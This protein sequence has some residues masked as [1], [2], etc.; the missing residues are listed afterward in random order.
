MGRKVDEAGGVGKREEG[1]L[2]HGGRESEGGRKK[3]LKF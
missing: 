2:G 1:G 3:K